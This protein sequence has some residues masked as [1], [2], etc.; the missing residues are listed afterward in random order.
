MK[1][2]EMLKKNYE[3]RFVLTKGKYYSGKYIYAF[4]IKNNLGKNRIGIAI[5]TKTGKAVKRNYLKR[6][7]KESYRLNEENAGIGKNIV[8]SIKNKTN[9]DEISFKLVQNDMI[10]I[11]KKIGQT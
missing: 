10:E 3:F 1:N 2:T 7:I 5:G 4:C 11:L 9:I 6:L 8:F